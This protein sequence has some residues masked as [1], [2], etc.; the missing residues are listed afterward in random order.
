MVFHYDFSAAFE[1]NNSESFC[2]RNVYVCCV[3]VL[4]VV[5]TGMRTNWLA[6][7]AS[8]ALSA[9]ATSSSTPVGF[10]SGRRDVGAYSVYVH[11]C[12]C[13]CRCTRE[14]F[15]VI[16]NPEDGSFL[17]RR[18]MGGVGFRVSARIIPRSF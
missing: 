15:V 14:I 7:T 9:S 11:A 2:H 3:L 8:W 12:A 16:R 6:N 17:P 18:R 10:W 4:R 1:R 13:F 5:W